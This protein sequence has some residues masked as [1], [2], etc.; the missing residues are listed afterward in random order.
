MADN[1]IDVNEGLP[2]EQ[3]VDATPQGKVKRWLA[4]WDLADAREKDW[5]E[6]SEKVWQIYNSKNA[7]GNS[8]NILWSN[9]E[10]LRPAAYN[11]MPEPDV[12]RRFRDADPVGKIAATVLERSIAF[13][14]DEY[15]FDD[16]IKNTVLD[17]LIPCRGVARIKYK[18]LFVQQET[19]KPAEDED[20]WLNGPADEEI[21]EPVRETL[22]GENVEVEHVVWDRYRHGPGKTWKEIPWLG[23]K[24]E[25][26]YSQLCQ[27]FGKEKAK[28]I[29]LADVEKSNDI[30][31]KTIRQ[32]FKVGIIYEI[33]DKSSRTVL[34]INEGFKE[35]PL[36]EVSDP[37]KL[38]GFFPSPR[39][40][41]AIED[42]TSMVP[43]ILYKKYEAQAIELNKVTFRINKIV[44]A[45]KVRGA[46]SAH[47]A[48]VPKILEALDNSMVPIENASEI[49]SMGGLDKAIW[50]MPIDKLIQVI[51]GLYKAREATIQ[52]IYQI[53]GL[54]DVMR[55][56]SNPHET[57]GAQKI[58]SQWGTLRLQRLQREVQRF[59]RDLFR[60]KSEVISNQFQPETLQLMTGIKL[61]TAKQKEQ[62]QQQLTAS[63]QAQAQAIQMQHAMTQAQQSGQPPQSSAMMPG[64]MPPVPMSPDDQA[65]AKKI[66]ALPTWDDVMKLLRSDA[67]RLYR[68]GVETDSTIQETVDRDLEGLQQA[69]IAVT[70]LFTA[71]APAVQMGY[72]SIEVVK[73][74]AQAVCRSAKMGQAVEDAIDQVMQ[75]PPPPPPVHPPDFSLQVAQVK[76]NADT[77]NAQTNAETQKNIAQLTEN[78]RIQV[79]QSREESRREALQI[80]SDTKAQIAQAIE[81][82]RQAIVAA[83]EQGKAAREQATQQSTESIS[84]QKTQL[85]A[86]VKI[87]VAQIAAA[88]E[89]D[90]AVEPIA[91]A[92]FVTQEE[93]Q[94]GQKALMELIQQLTKQHQDSQIQTNEQITG[95]HAAVHAPK[96][97]DLTKDASG[98]VVGA[99]ATPIL[100]TS[101]ATG[102]SKK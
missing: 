71:F 85:D 2:T 95:I 75:P 77:Q 50:M 70:Q 74:L 8:F 73:S 92:Q 98:R 27:M 3:E 96:K 81:A 101:S 44:D 68:V 99:V 25:M 53:T 65:N 72:M 97:V 43:A 58:K 5:R 66:L 11:S 1:E 47:L 30:S 37:L 45:M 34:F 29:K 102:A 100:P 32:L 16:E 10:T 63:A 62:M 24:H 7:S 59:I 41:Y 94:K 15:D 87:L 56:V 48:E 51:E 46:Y 13:S 61:P 69:I 17:T 33:W 35:G 39:P 55:G 22:A 49:A 31:D 54:G 79:E 93:N 90:E 19:A 20:A 18:P 60:L 89:A 42:S 84:E 9:T 83:Q 67:M 64:Q 6:E 82:S 88:K 86:A 4:E 12:R 26:P 21:N 40:I 52:V 14:I 23:Y 91:E 36:L 38:L 28:K 80:Q 57:F 78:T 76:A